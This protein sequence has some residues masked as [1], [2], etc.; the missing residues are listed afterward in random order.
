M[1]NEIKSV[2]EAAAFL[3][4]DPKVQQG[5]ER[6]IARSS[7]VTALINLRVHKGY[8]QKQIAEAMRCDP[9][10]I[11]KLE[12]GNDLSLKWIDIVGYLMAM[13]MNIS[14]VFDDDTLPAAEQIKQH[15]FR[16]HALLERL[17]DLAKE[18]DDD[19]E[20]TDKIHQFYGEVLFNFVTRFGDSYAK[21]T[22]V[23]K[24]PEQEARELLF[25]RKGKHDARTG[26]KE[27][28]SC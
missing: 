25:G 23:L 15:V 8:T 5:V 10:K 3:A 11:S 7:L 6:E 28:V 18:V 4:D 24:I 17:A 21:L 2:A 16:I 19:R 20:L 13:D 12:S 22:S 1:N 26:K 27:P 14:L 9:S